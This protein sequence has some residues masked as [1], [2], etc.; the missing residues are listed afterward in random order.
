MTSG[1]H[2]DLIEANLGALN[3]WFDERFALK[4]QEQSREKV[5]SL[6]I[7][8]T[9]GTLDWA[10]P[11]FIIESTARALGWE[12]TLFFTFYGL[13]LLKKDL[14]LKISPLGNP[15]MPMKMPFGPPWFRDIEW[16]MPNLIMAGVP[17]FENLATGLMKETLRQKGVAPIRE[18]REICVETGVKLI[19]CQMTVDLFGWSKEQF[20]E[21]ISEWAGAASYLVIARESDVSLYT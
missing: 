1:S 5:P 16:N 7:M 20:I 11:P 15:A 12:V 2:N 21:D 8:V 18:L 17:G 9:K 6:S 3:H 19:A 4:I 10:Y 13:A 14:D